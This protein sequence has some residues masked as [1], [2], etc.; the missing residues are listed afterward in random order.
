MEVLRAHRI[1]SERSTGGYPH[2]DLQ[3]ATVQ[4]VS[5]SEGSQ[6]LSAQG[7]PCPH[8]I[9]LLPTGLPFEMVIAP[10]HFNNTT[11]VILLYA[12]RLV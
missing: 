1:G 10:C 3:E 12:D 6:R 8:L 9:T 7:E 4:T 2:I 11:Y 5:G